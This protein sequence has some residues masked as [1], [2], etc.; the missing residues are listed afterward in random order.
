M[1]GPWV[2]H[3]SIIMIKCVL[4]DFDGTLGDTNSGILET[5]KK[6]MD[7][8]GL[9]RPTDEAITATIGLP[10]K[11]NFL[12]AVTGISDE[13]A[14]RCVAIYR[15]MFI[16]ETI[17]TI[18]FFPGVAETLESLEEMGIKMA[19]ATSR[20]HKTLDRILDNLGATHYFDRI[21][22]ADEVVHHKP[23]PETV[24]IVL[25]HF[26]LQPSEA[27]VVGD[28]TYDIQMGQNAGC[29]VCGVTWGNHSREVLSSCTPD[30]IIDSMT[31][32]T[33]ICSDSMK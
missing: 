21:C 8:L 2:R 23:A 9:E 32:L 4:F 20:T 11:Q 24:E 30:F 13:M 6:T 25:K 31:E 19:I 10:L 16:E 26:G 14:D 3:F 29:R 17:P 18:K 27:I 15:K 5:F 12:D 1:P 7:I 33:G 22:C 28:T